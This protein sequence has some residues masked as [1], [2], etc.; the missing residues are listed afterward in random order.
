MSFLIYFLFRNHN[1]SIESQRQKKRNLIIYWNGNIMC[2]CDWTQFTFLRFYECPL[3]HSR[4]PPLWSVHAAAKE[5]EILKP[6]PQCLAEWLLA[7]HHISQIVPYECL[8]Q[9]I[10][11][12][13]LFVVVPI[14]ELFENPF[15]S[16]EPS[17]IFV[18]RTL[19]FLV[20]NALIFLRKFH[21]TTIE[22]ISTQRILQNY[23]EKEENGSFWLENNCEQIVYKSLASIL[24][25]RVTVEIIF[26]IGYN[27][28]VDWSWNVMQFD[29]ILW[30]LIK[31]DGL[32]L[33]FD[34]HFCRIN[35]W[36]L[37][38]C[39]SK[40]WRARKWCRS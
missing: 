3:C 14:V 36:Q 40:K 18:Q 31:V 1:N 10:I 7:T 16:E 20:H 25:I 24:L 23:R 34:G 27:I 32:Y 37:D 13:R 29:V 15:G 38:F 21:F 17:G 4:I 2:L 26:H 11:V 35:C 28:F 39:L 19:W 8:L 22:W 33:Q 9:C 30:R 5:E 6:L 12:G